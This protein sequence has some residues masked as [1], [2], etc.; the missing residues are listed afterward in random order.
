M[1]GSLR[2][3]FKSGLGI[4]DNSFVTGNNDNAS[5]SHDV[6]GSKKSIYMLSS[7]DVKDRRVLSCFNVRSCSEKTFIKAVA[8]S[9]LK[10]LLHWYDMTK[11]HN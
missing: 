3:S 9:M 6:G 8:Y 7:M 4:A 2:L 1:R 11:L 5:D 10:S